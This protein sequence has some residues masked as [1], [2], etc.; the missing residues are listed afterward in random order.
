MASNQQQKAWASAFGLTTNLLHLQDHVSQPHPTWTPRNM[1]FDFLN[2]LL[3][4]SKWV[5]KSLKMQQHIFGATVPAFGHLLSVPG[6][7]KAFF[8]AMSTGESQAPFWRLSTA[9]R[10]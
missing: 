7:S 9:C 4:S 5:Y 8:A 3:L 6:A 1:Y 2:T 10:P